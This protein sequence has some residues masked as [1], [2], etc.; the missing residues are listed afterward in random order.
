MPPS[1]S[2]T[3]PQEIECYCLL[4]MQ[5]R[6]GEREQACMHHVGCALR[7]RQSVLP[8]A[9]VMNMQQ[10]A[11]STDFEIPYESL[12]DVPPLLVG[13]S[14]VPPRA[15]PPPETDVTWPLP[16]SCPAKQEQAASVRHL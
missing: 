5:E 12:R 11:F 1:S 16:D 7:L 10:G 9:D 2:H 13:V 14:S 8:A 15:A 4:C 6:Q 3:A